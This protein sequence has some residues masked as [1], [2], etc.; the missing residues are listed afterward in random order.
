MLMAICTLAQ[1]EE[2]MSEEFWERGY[3]ILEEVLTPSQIDLAVASLGHKLDSQSMRKRDSGHVFKAEDE[4]S[5]G[6]GE[7]LLRHCQPAF[8]EAIGRPLIESFA[9]W[10]VYHSGARL[11]RHTDRPGCEISA[12][13]TLACE[14]RDADWPIMIE[15]TNSNVRAVHLKPGSTLLYQ[16]HKVPHWRDT[17]DGTRQM[18]LLFHYVLKDG[19]FAERSFDGRDAD[20]VAGYYVDI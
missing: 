13:L 8:E 1:G 10:R 2:Q 12:T 15:D 16:G 18:Q 19:P 5:P 7:L 17:F 3:C 4:Y 9:Y 14:P 6:I 11:T 20:P